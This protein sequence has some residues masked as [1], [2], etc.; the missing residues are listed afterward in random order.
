MVEKSIVEGKAKWKE[1]E[2]T[3]EEMKY[4]VDYRIINKSQKSIISRMII[5]RTK[6]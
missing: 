1:T 2:K 4:G 3:R 6:T 5:P